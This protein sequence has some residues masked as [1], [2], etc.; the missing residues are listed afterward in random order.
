MMAGQ[1]LYTGK[2]P[3]ELE[4]EIE[5]RRGELRAS[6]KQL[7][8]SMRP[9]TLATR[10][11][12]RVIDSGIESA[13]HIAAN[14]I[15]RAN[16]WLDERGRKPG[17]TPADRAMERALSANGQHR[18]T[19]DEIRLKA[20]VDAL[21]SDLADYSS[22]SFEDV[23]QAVREHAAEYGPKLRRTARRAGEKMPDYALPAVAVLGLVAVVAYASSN[24]R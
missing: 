18:D 12:N 14:S 16:A 3:A 4:R 9:S 20:R 15:R 17:K 23:I 24:R 13:S 22:Q 11:A 1:A 5:A 2:S 8:H 21:K 6:T 19:H 7:V 10:A